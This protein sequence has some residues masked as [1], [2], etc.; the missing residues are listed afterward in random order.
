[1]SKVK[2]YEMARKVGMSNKDFLMKLQEWGIEVK[3]N[4]QNNSQNYF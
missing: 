3:I 1:M 2:V 4:E